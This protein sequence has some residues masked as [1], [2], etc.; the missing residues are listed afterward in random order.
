MTRQ[1][2][3]LFGA[4]AISIAAGLLPGP[5]SADA[6]FKKWINGFYSTAAKSGISEKPIVKRR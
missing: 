4:I 2:R 6:G 3:R 5:A 1:N